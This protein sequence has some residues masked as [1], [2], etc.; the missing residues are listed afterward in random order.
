M[1]VCV[2]LLLSGDECLQV[3]SV[4]CV[5]AVLSHST[6]YCMSFIHGDI[7]GI[8]QQSHSQPITA[9]LTELQS[10]DCVCLCLRVPV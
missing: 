10:G 5:S 1:C 7:P 9:A 6:Q 4:Q 8:T 2:Q 3:A